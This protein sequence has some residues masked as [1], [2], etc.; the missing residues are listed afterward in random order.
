MNN[1]S[2]IKRILETELLAKPLQG[3]LSFQLV[4]GEQEYIVLCLDGRDVKEG[5]FYDFYRMSHLMPEN[6]QYHWNILSDLRDDGVRNPGLCEAW[7]FWEGWAEY[8]SNSPMENIATG[9]L[10]PMLLAILDDRFSWG[11]LILINHRLLRWPPILQY[12]Y[13][14]RTEAEGLQI[15]HK[16][17]R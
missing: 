16:L 4:A 5:A 17:T 9:E 12:V 1:W 7:E 14:L 2:E 6:P 11:E 13:W 10:I 8:R 3:R 15:P